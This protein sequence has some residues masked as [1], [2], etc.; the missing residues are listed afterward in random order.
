MHSLLR[1]CDLYNLLQRRVVSARPQHRSDLSRVRDIMRQLK[2]VQ[3]KIN[4]HKGRGMYEE[5]EWF[6]AR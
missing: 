5:Y 1:E 6:C 2:D 4:P 3:S